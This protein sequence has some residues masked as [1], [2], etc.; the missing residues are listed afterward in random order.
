M[1]DL[2]EEHFPDEVFNGTT[3]DLVDLDLDI[4]LSVLIRLTGIHEKAGFES[5]FDLLL[6]TTE[7]CKHLSCFAGPQQRKS[8]INSS[9]LPQIVW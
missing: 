6:A 5:R 8:A 4:Y 3:W 7:G 2:N 1:V 9:R